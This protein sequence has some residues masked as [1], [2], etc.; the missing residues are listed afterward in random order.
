MEIEIVIFAVLGA[1][2]L[3]P[4]YRLLRLL[5]RIRAVRRLERRF[6]YH[7]IWSAGITWI[8]GILL[9]IYLLINGFVLVL[10]RDDLERWAG[11]VAA[12]NSIPLF[13]GG[14]RNIFIHYFGLNAHN[15][16]HCIIGFVVIVEGLL[17]AGL[18]FSRTQFRTS[19]WEYLVRTQAL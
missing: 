7:V 16:A 2:A 6:R 14:R 1:I 5:R 19:P 3:Y 18:A 8:G 15:V 17:H 12:V 11:V 9:S 10:L 4:I 13:L